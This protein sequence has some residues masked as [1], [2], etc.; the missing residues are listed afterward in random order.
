MS[1]PSKDPRPRRLPDLARWVVILGALAW[2]LPADGL[3]QAATGAG[4][5]ILDR[6]VQQ[7]PRRDALVQ[8][9]LRTHCPR[10]LD[11][12]GRITPRVVVI[13]WTG[14]RS[15]EGAWRYFNRLEAEPGRAELYRQGRLNVGT[16]FLV[17][18]D[19]IVLQLL[20]ENVLARHVIGLNTTAIGIDMVGRSARD[21]T[22]AQ[23][24]SVAWLVRQLATRYPI[25]QVVGH[26]ETHLLE[27]S[28]AWCEVVPGYRSRKPDP[29]PEFMRRLR[30]RLADLDLD[31][32]PGGRP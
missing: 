6:P 2:G 9:Y 32:L 8:D 11:S 22:D 15:L 31:P 29:G 19:G 27:G 1:W 18:A 26:H 23:L 25:R 20:P 28:D 12:K 14:G 21:L 24:D 13:H 16:H 3:A 4:R 17:G 7:G 10:H 5:T 30:A